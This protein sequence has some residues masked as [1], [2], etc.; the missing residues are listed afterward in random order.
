MKKVLFI[1]RD[2]TLILEPFD[3]QIDSIEKLTFYPEMFRYLG[4]IARWL[5]YELVM[6]TNQDGLGSES[7]PEE[8]F[9]PI[10]DLIMRTL[11]NEGIQF[12]AVHIDRS[13]PEENA[14]TRKP[15]LGMLKEYLNGNIDLANS[16]VIGDRLTDVQLAANLG[17]K[18][19]RLLPPDQ[20]DIA[21]N[22]PDTLKPVIALETQTWEGV[23]KFMAGNMR[24]AEIVRKTKET[25]IRINLNL[26]GTGTSEINT[27][28]KFFDH[29]LEQ[30]AMHG[31]IELKIIVKGDLDVDEHHTVED[32][33]LALGT[34][35]AKA[36]GD[37]KGM[38]RYGFCL[39]MDD[40]LAQ[41]AIDF[42][43]RPWLVWKVKFKR[44]YVGDVPTEMFYHFF[45]SFSD[46]ARINLNI[47][48]KG[49]NEH[50]KIEAV[51]KAVARAIRMA[52]RTDFENASLPST[53]GTL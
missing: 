49:D 37:K 30:I 23:W 4:Q 19:I 48:A 21:L 18:A 33:A 41:A 32:T 47:Q 36:I 9:L 46:A 38:G 53:K 31:G 28:L 26:D 35:F 5:N 50:H 42:G 6:V 22:I 25:D 43:G 17:C 10:H 12:S 2:G 14:L 16:F 20:S 13:F 27:G 51:F 40:C 11:K 45:K 15:E 44:E 39:P 7:Y 34:A 52:I 3:F 8:I 24:K 29:M 1:D